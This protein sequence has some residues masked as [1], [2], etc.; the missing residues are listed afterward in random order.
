MISDYSWR[1]I[2]KDILYAHFF[3]LLS[4]TGG[5]NKAKLVD[6]HKVIISYTPGRSYTSYCHGRKRPSC[7]SNFI[8][9]RLWYNWIERRKLTKTPPS[10]SHPLPRLNFTPLFLPLLPPMSGAGGIGNRQSVCNCSFL[11]FFPLRSFLLVQ[12]SSLSWAAVL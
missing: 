3:L 12:W 1:R 4:R 8:Y 5:E 11:I 6:W 2:V 9:C 7:K 10:P